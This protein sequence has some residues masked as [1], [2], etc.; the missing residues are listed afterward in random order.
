MYSL[1]KVDNK[2]V[3]LTLKAISSAASSSSAFFCNSSYDMAT[4]A[5][6]KL[7]R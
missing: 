6:I 2:E 1:V 3:T 5:K 4:I 7:T